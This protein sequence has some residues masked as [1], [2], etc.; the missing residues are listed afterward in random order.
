VNG[1]TYH[2]VKF[3]TVEADRVHFTA[4]DGLGSFMLADLSP[5][6]KKRFNYDPAKAEITAKKRLEDQQVATQ[7][8]APT[9]EETSQV[10]SKDPAENEAIRKMV[11]RDKKIQADDLAHGYAHC[12]GRILQILPNGFIADL[13]TRWG[14]YYP[15]FVK[16]DPKSLIDDQPWSGILI[17][18]NTYQ[19]TTS[20]GALATIP[21]F[22]T[23]LKETPSAPV[24]SNYTAPR[25]PV[26]SSMSVGGGN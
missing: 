3:G 16:C 1:K 6:L 2:N 17:P 25:A 12:S 11:E 15:C 21:A 18:Q 7:S 4:D 22:T 8:L 5:E 9:E 20:L 14:I 19:Y 23:N 26:S 24:A 13:S 10:Y